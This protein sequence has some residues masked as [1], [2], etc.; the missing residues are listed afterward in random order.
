MRACLIVSK[1]NLYTDLLLCRAQSAGV[2]AQG[3]SEARQPSRWVLPLQRP[4]AGSNF[5]AF[6]CLNVLDELF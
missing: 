2:V 4:Y 3:H 1:S 5:K 6:K